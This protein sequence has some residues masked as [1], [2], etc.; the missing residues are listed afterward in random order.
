MY[1]TIASP[2][3][4][5]TVA[6]MISDEA[7]AEAQRR[8]LAHEMSEARHAANRRTARRQARAAGSRVR[9]VLAA[10]AALA[11]ALGL[12][13]AGTASSDAPG[14]GRHGPTVVAKNSFP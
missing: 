11:L 2:A 12:A 6:A 9:P 14:T 7:I 3:T 10:G 13:A 8:H 1:P 5:L 4:A